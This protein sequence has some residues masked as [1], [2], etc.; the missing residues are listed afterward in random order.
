[1]LDTLLAK[2]VGTQNDRELKRLR[3]IVAEVNAL[4]PAIQALS[5][6][7]LRGK[8]AEFRQRARQRRDARR[9]AAGSL[10][11]RPRGRPPRAQHAALRRAAHRRR[12]AP[13]GQ[14]RR[15]EDRRG[16][17]A[18][19]DAARLPQRARRQGRPRR[20]RQR[21]PRP[22]RLGVDGQDLPLPRDDGRRHPARPQR[23]RA[24]GRLRR[25]HHLRHEQRVRLRLP[26]RQHEVRA[27]ALRAARAPLRDRRRGRQHP[28]RRGADAAHHLR[29]G[30]GV[31]RPVLRGRPHHPEAE[32]GRRHPAATPRPRIA[33]RS[34]RPATTS[35]TRSTRPSR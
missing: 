13:Q 23:R 5:D 9:S 18:R 8:T 14:D 16:Q 31:D 2:V 32:D 11:R 21:L 10:R 1:M 19:R 35:R 3:P 29:P 28:H 33:R 17:D 34:K 15:D 22:P 4:E 25:R 6:E 7:Q 20:H 27:R 24:A 26:P 30:R 12:G